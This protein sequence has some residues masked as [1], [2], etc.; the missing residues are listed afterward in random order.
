MKQFSVFKEWMRLQRDYH[1]KFVHL[2]PLDML[3]KYEDN[4]PVLDKFTNSFYFF[5]V[6]MVLRADIQDTQKE[7]RLCRLTMMV[8]LFGKDYV[9]S[10]ILLIPLTITSVTNAKI[11]LFCHVAVNNLHLWRCCKWH[12]HALSENYSM[13]WCNLVPRDS[14]QPYLDAWKIDEWARHSF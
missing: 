4:E 7:Q 12:A 13:M 5:L 10:L 2:I 9:T 11:F 14:V 1:Y 3:E 8:A 6:L